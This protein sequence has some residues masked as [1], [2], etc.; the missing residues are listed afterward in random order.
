[1]KFSKKSS[2]NRKTTKRSM[3]HKYI[4]KRGG[5]FN[6]QRCIN[7]KTEIY[8]DGNSKTPDAIRKDCN[9]LNETY[10]RK[11]KPGDENVGII[12]ALKDQQETLEDQIRGLEEEQERLMKENEVR[13][14]AI[15]KK[16]LEEARARYTQK[17]EAIRK[18]KLLKSRLVHVYDKYDQQNN[19]NE[20]E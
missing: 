1:M 5:G 4:K 3:K 13:Q 6:I 14:V 20:D 10:V 18:E 16:A 19:D 11:I 8:K 7:G 15:D 2:K 12:V 9:T 17:Q